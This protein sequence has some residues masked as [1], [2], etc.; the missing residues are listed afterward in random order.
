MVTSRTFS[1]YPTVV[2]RGGD[3]YDEVH[4]DIDAPGAGLTSA[5]T[6]HNKA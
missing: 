1:A 2:S 3:N 4:L 6:I 5:E